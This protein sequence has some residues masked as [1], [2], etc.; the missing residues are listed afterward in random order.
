MIFRD[1]PAINVLEEHRQA[2]ASIRRLHSGRLLPRTVLSFLLPILPV[3]PALTQE[4][5]NADDSDKPAVE[6]PVVPVAVLYES[7]NRRDPFFHYTPTKS[8]QKDDVDNEVPRGT[9][10]PGITGTFIEKAGLEGIVVR[11]NNRRTAV[12]RGADNRAYFLH[13]GDRLFD[14]YLETIQDDSVVFVRET[15][16]RSGKIQTQ[17]ITKRLRKS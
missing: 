10:P 15:F 5:E 1:S 6:K 16:M 17:E 14:G 3:L 2:R 7:N 9:P 4:K 8:A 13:E 12:I 11:N